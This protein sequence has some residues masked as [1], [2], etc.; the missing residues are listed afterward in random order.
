MGAPAPGLSLRMMNASGTAA[1]E[2]GS[3]AGYM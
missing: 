3:N 2:T 1:A